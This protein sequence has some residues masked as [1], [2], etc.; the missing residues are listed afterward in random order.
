MPVTG[1][2][3]LIKYEC[4]VE[5]PESHDKDLDFKVIPD[6]TYSVLIMDKTPE[7]IGASIRRFYSEYVPKMK[8]CID[9]DRPVLEMYTEDTM[10]YFVPITEP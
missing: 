9:P 10:E 8:L 5:I 7:V 1:E 6:G 3:G 2:K 4:C